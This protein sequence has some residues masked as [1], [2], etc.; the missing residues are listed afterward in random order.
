MNDRSAKRGGF[1][2]LLISLIVVALQDG[3]K[4]KYRTLLGNRAGEPAA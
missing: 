4:Q 2:A 1:L 3:V